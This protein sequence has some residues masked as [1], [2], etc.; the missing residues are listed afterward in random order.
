MGIFEELQNEMRAIEEDSSYDG[1]WYSISDALLVLVCGLLCGLQRVIDIHDWATSAPTKVFLSKHFGMERVFCLAQFYN[2]LKLVDAEKFKFSFTRWMKLVL[3]DGVKGKTVAIDGKTVCGTDKLTEDGSV[4]HIAS[5]II[6]E[7]NLVIATTQCNT[8]MG[9]IAAFRELVA[10]LN[11]EGAVVVADAL[12]CNPKSADAVIEAGA[13]YLFVVKD[14]Q[15]N[16]KEDIEFY[17][18]THTATSHTTKEKN[19]G[20]L[21]TRT[22]YTDCDIGWLLD[23]Q[24]WSELSCIGAIHRQFEKDNTKSSEWHFYISSKALTPAELLNHARLEWAV[25]SLHWLLDVHY[26]ED[27]TRIWD[28]NVQKLLNIARKIALNLIRIYKEANRTKRTPLS[29]VMRENLFDLERLAGFLE[30]FIDW[31]FMELE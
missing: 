28:M 12:H 29:K 5:A 20:R 27:K 21:E 18:H 10:M 11:V 30:F 24:K 8:K 3:S 13:D 15:K 9:E 22:A 14:N 26:N 1:Y 4:L 19:G 23:K 31:E 25:E 6:S 7:L 16:L 17:F 2:I